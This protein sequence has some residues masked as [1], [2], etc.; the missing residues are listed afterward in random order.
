MR[1]S[2]QVAQVHLH[3]HTSSH[4]P[5]ESG[6]NS[7]WYFY[8]SPRAKGP[9]GHGSRFRSTWVL[10]AKLRVTQV[11]FWIVSK[12]V[13]WIGILMETGM[14]LFSLEKASSRLEWCGHVHSCLYIYAI[15]YWVLHIYDIYTQTRTYIYIYVCVVYLCINTDKYTCTYGFI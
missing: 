15:L 2:L 11:M 14:I 7:A 5:Q 6:C 13:S 4:P 12:C 9:W 1:S 3:I 10:F 8:H